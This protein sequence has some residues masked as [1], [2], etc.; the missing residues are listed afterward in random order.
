MFIMMR[1]VSIKSTLLNNNFENASNRLP[2]V[3]IAS[4]ACHSV[5][6]L[7]LSKTAVVVFMTVPS[8]NFI[9]NSGIIFCWSFL[10]ILVKEFNGD[11]L[12][13]SSYLSGRYVKDCWGNRFDC[14]RISP[15]GGIKLL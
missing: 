10:F 11:I 3:L 15:V 13:G 6:H 1:Y 7:K 4:R 8:T 14:V 12:V 9:T 5:Y 2:Y